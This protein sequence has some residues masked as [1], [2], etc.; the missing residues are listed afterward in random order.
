MVASPGAFALNAV[1]EGGL[2]SMIIVLLGLL[3]PDSIFVLGFNR[4]AKWEYYPPLPLLSG[5]TACS[6]AT[7]NRRDSVTAAGAV[8]AKV[9]FVGGV[10]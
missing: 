3:N 4:S 1:C 8:Q 10:A 2:V 9:S 7:C 6:R 5:T